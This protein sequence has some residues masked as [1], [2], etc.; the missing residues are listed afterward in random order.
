MSRMLLISR[1]GSQ[2]IR[3]VI[4]HLQIPFLG[5]VNLSIGG[6]GKKKVFGK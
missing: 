2:R 4:L 6:Q 1:M 3:L 5:N